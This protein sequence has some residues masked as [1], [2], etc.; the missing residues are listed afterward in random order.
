MGETASPSPGWIQ[1]TGE[2]FM[3]EFGRPW[4]S[5]A[6]EPSERRDRGRSVPSRRQDRRIPWRRT[7]SRAKYRHGPALRWQVGLMTTPR[8]G[9]LGHTD[10]HVVRSLTDRRTGSPRSRSRSARCHRRRRR[11]NGHQFELG[12]SPGGPAGRRR[13]QCK[14]SANSGSGSKPARG[15]S[16]HG[17]ENDGQRAMQH[18]DG[19]QPPTVGI[20]GDSGRCQYEY[21]DSVVRRESQGCWSSGSRPQCEHARDA[22]GQQSSSQHSGQ[23]IL[24][25]CGRTPDERRDHGTG[26]EDQRGSRQHLED[27]A[28]PKDHQRLH[29]VRQHGSEA[30]VLHPGWVKQDLRTRPETPPVIIAL[31]HRRHREGR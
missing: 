23:H 8:N 25:R 11:L 31:P 26:H 7:D 3:A 29:V 27:G 19:P 18:D 16:P 12:R 13:G 17:N 22:E 15:T 28:R 20:A 5:T 9:A 1:R 4:L 14:P 6:R 2:R 21:G 10:H 30:G 24:D